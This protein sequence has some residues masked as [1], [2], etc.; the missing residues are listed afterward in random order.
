MFISI[1]CCLLSSAYAEQKLP[2]ALNTWA[3]LEANQVAWAVLHEPG[4]SSLDALVDGVTTCEDRHCDGSVGYGGSPD[5]S[6]ETTLDS[7]IIDGSNMNVGAVAGLRHIKQAIRTARFVLEHTEH[8]LLVGDAASNFAEM[9]GLHR[10]SLTTP[11]SK[12][13]WL[14]WKHYN[15]QPN[16]WVNVIP[17][18]KK[19]CGPYKP[20]SKWL[21][22]NSNTKRLECKMNQRNH[23]TIGMIVINQRGQIYAG[24]STNGA[25]HKIPGRVGDSPI[26]GAG[27]YADNEVGAAVATGDGDIMMR[28]LPSL[29]AVEALRSGKTPEDAATYSI[30]RIAHY[31]SDFSGAVVVVDRW[32]NYSA[33]CIGMKKF[34]YSVAQGKHK[35]IIK[36]RDCI[37][38]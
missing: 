16:F 3:F 37:V 38:T 10:E 31:Y 36:F 32:G 28:F 14:E 24:T 4:K 6:G 9:M 34:P 8:S 33:A 18:P 21:T 19:R 29:L 25:T 11:A 1:V 13:M 5:E 2:V 27:A 30:E 20:Q 7:M 15:C 22:T 35:S 26:P 12:A 17:D 23:D